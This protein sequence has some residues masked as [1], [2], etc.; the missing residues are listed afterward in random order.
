MSKFR[1]YGYNP[2]VTTAARRRD[3]E[4]LQQGFP[5]ILRNLDGILRTPRLF[6]CQLGLAY[7][8]CWFY[9]G[10]GP[11]PL[12]VLALVWRDGEMIHDCP[13]CGGRFHAIGV[14]GLLGGG[15]TWGLCAD[16]RRYGIFSPAGWFQ[17]LLAV[18]PLLPQYRNQ[19]IIEH[20]K[21]PRFDWKHGLVGETTPDRVILPAVEPLAL[22]ALIAELEAAEAGAVIPDQGLETAQPRTNT[23]PTAFLRIQ[24]GHGMLRIPFSADIKTLGDSL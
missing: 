23:S 11:I 18:A 2:K 16:C 10:D 14:S 13:E 3:I 12:G 6:Y 7:V 4:A 24:K 1:V 20:G 9:G 21:R 17:G 19:P 5:L 15:S 22:S 8:S